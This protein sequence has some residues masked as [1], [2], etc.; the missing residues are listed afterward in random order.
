MFRGKSALG[1]AIFLFVLLVFLT[2]MDGAGEQRAMY[3]VDAANSGFFSDVSINTTYTPIPFW[4]EESSFTEYSNPIIIDVNDDGKQDIIYAIAGGTLKVLEGNYHTLWEFETGA[5]YISTPAAADIDKDGDLDIVFASSAFDG[6]NEIARLYCVSHRGEEKWNYTME[7]FAET[8]FPTIADLTNDAGLE[9]LISTGMKT[10]GI[11][12]TTSLY[13]LSSKGKEIWEYQSSDLHWEILGTPTVMNIIDDSSPE[14]IFG[15][16]GN[17]GLFV[18]DNEGKVVWKQNPG[19]RYTSAIAYDID[20][21][22]RPEVIIGVDSDIYCYDN[23]GGEL[24]HTQLAEPVF[25]TPFA[26]DIDADGKVEILVASDKL[27][28]L[29]ADGDIKWEQ[30]L[31]EKAH[32][33][34]IA[35][36]D[37]DSGSPEILIGDINGTLYAFSNLGD[38]LWTVQYGTKIQASPYVG[39][40]NDDGTPEVFLT[41]QRSERVVSS[42]L[43]LPLEEIT[44]Q[45]DFEI[46]Q[47]TR[48]PAIAVADH[49][50]TY[51]VTVINKGN[52]FSST[53][54]ILVVDNITVDSKFV[55][56]PSPRLDQPDGYP[57]EVTLSWI[58]VTGDHFI[59]IIIDPY[60][61]IDELDESNNFFTTPLTVIAE[62]IDIVV[63]KDDI[64]VSQIEDLDFYRLQI[65][66]WN[67]GNL[68]TGN[69]TVKLTVNGVDED[70]PVLGLEPGTSTVKV[71][72]L[73]LDLGTDFL[74]S[75]E[76]DSEGRISEANETNNIADKIFDLSSSPD[77]SGSNFSFDDWS[78]LLILI[79]VIL[80]A[81]AIYYNNR[82]SKQNYDQM[83][84]TLNE[85]KNNLSRPGEPSHYPPWMGMQDQEASFR[86]WQRSAPNHPPTIADEAGG[87]PAERP[88]SVQSEAPGKEMSPEAEHSNSEANIGTSG[89]SVNSDPSGTSGGTSPPPQPVPDPIP[90]TSS[91]KI[92]SESG[93]PS[94][95]STTAENRSSSDESNDIPQI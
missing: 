33:S 46:G 86:E 79:P 14:I 16:T 22:G 4:E 39:D 94:V 47:V 27:Y 53:E 81:I 82:S 13:C 24:W 80:L 31:N 15:I 25:C 10:I 90:E 43:D 67:L 50:I 69:F 83:Q 48:S 77:D 2:S 92:Q 95:D 34:S 7:A 70:L 30:S 20:N 84:T 76:A 91:G 28:C 9:V 62:Y 56:I 5:T 41:L 57:E 23:M 11:S 63:T 19:Y 21:A 49:E 32:Y 64:T 93:K 55:P 18:L 73:N 1:I 3:Q 29:D 75:V 35:F 52:V 12:T 38:L 45:F 58:G 85:L 17:A 51:T 26:K 8:S 54:L 36:V 71:K 42:F 78:L 44:P 65:E 61:D 40:V 59:Q 87:P 66:I 74:V 88:G 89:H 60:E 6:E 37:I 72:T 68:P